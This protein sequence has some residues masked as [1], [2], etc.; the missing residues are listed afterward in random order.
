MF[1]AEL[2]LSITYAVAGP[3]L[4][5]LNMIASYPS[6][7]TIGIFGK[8]SFIINKTW[9]LDSIPGAADQ[10]HGSVS[11]LPE[12]WTEPQQTGRS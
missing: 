2:S 10:G 8:Y 7:T 1:C 5:D 11:S 6:A 4:V 12:V 3:T 9:K